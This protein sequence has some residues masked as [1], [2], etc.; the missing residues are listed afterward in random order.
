MELKR[1]GLDFKETFNQVQR[2]RKHSFRGL[3]SFLQLYVVSNG[4]DTKYNPQTIFLTLI[5]SFA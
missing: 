1:R 4:V 2:Y 5:M 3:F